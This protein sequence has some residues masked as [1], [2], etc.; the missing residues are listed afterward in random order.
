MKPFKV[1]SF[2]TSERKPLHLAA[3]ELGHGL[4]TRSQSELASIRR[5]LSEV[6]D[7]TPDEYARGFLDAIEQVLAGLS[8]E[9]KHRRAVAEDVAATHLRKNATKVLLALH[10]GCG[11]PSEIAE[12]T[13]LNLP[14]V[15]NELSELERE[16]L[17]E[18]VERAAGGDQ[19]TSPRALSIRGMQVAD[20]LTRAQVSPAAEAARDLAPVFVSF[21][22]QLADESY[23][24]PL[25]F[26]EAAIER[27]GTINGPFV[28]AEFM[29]HA[30]RQRMISFTN[31][32]ITLTSPF[33]RGRLRDLLEDALSSERAALLEPM[34]QLADTAAVCLRA[35]TA[36]RDRWKMALSFHRMRNVY[37]WC[38]DDA[39]AQQLPSPGGPYHVVWENPEVMTRDLEDHGLRPFLSK[40]TRRLCYLATDLQLPQGVERIE[41]DAHHVGG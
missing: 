14:A 9:V 8:A 36:M 39:R 18:R 7:G 21:I 17:V 12:K 24:A 31:S 5:E 11:L 35:T 15:S 25:R 23:L 33:Y 34:K 40:A 41:L 30:E 1:A 4:Q 16:H 29:R 3:R 19:R 32:A 26:E 2:R 37:A 27:L 10:A 6:A 13:R 38:R 22:N 28:C 20:H